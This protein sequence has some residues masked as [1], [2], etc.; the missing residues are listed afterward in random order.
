MHFISRR[1]PEYYHY[2]H[3]APHEVR[4]NQAANALK[5]LANGG[6]GNTA[7]KLKLICYNQSAPQR[8]SVHGP[9]RP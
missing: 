2:L 6:C 8:I 5:P 3:T 7:A 9:I 1:P 4:T